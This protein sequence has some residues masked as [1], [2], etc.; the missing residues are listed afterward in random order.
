[1]QKVF[2]EVQLALGVERGHAGARAGAAGRAIDSAGPGGGTLPV[3]LA[4]GNDDGVLGMCARL[5][6]RRGEDG[7]GN[8]REGR[9]LRMH[10]RQL[11]VGRG[12]DHLADAY[13]VAAFIRR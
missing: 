3:E 9:L 11:L 10:D 6:R 13:N 4:G 12:L 7:N 5:S 2:V 1:M 8:A